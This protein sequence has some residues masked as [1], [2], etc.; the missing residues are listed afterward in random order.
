[1]NNQKRI[2][3]S[4]ILAM[5]ALI[6]MGGVWQ[7]AAARTDTYALV[8]GETIDFG[9]Q[10]LAVSNIPIGVSQV[11]MDTVGRQQLPRLKR[12][13]DIKYRLPALAV[14][15][16]NEH[17][18][19]VEDI[20]ALVYVFFNITKAER[21]AWFMGGMNDIAIW[22]VNEETLQWEICPTMFVNDGTS[23]R[24]ACLAPGSGYYVLSRGD[25]GKYL[26][27]PIAV[28]NSSEVQSANSPFP[29][30]LTVRAYVDG[31]SQ[32]IIKGDKL[33]WRHL[34]FAAPGR[35]FDAKVS[36]P[37]YL[38]QVGW[39]PDW[40]NA[41]DSENR[42]CHCNSSTYKGIPYLANTD[43]LVRLQVVQARGKVFILQ[44]PNATTNYTL[45]IELD[46]NPLMGPDWYEVNLSY[47]VEPDN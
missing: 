24:L 28:G 21:A 35:H 33:F 6:T 17:G 8:A 29:T 37:T 20:N 18:G 26:I 25:F 27:K 19:I 38:N 13:I 34:D 42:D 10:G 1:M 36:Q 12:E 11:Y 44:Q 16:L 47:T 46:D 4:F 5:T 30:T 22:Y 32:L 14:R 39:E 2:T 43:Q 40:P 3:L 15:F 7:P 23:D 45:I 31:R 41:P 9:R